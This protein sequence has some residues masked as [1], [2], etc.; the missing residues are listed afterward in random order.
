MNQEEKL[1]QEIMSEAKAQAE[2]TAAHAQA[3]ADEIIDR[4]RRDVAKKRE[5]MLAEANA[6]AE[7]QAQAMFTGI[8]MEMSRRWLLK[9][10][11]CI[12]DLLQ[13]ALAKA[14]K[15]EG[16]DR[17]A[18]LASL[19][20]EAL[21]EIGDRDCMVSFNPADGNI[22]TTAWLQGLSK[23]IYPE[24]TITYTLKPD[25][26]VDGGIVLETTDGARQ[27]DNSYKTRLLRMK[28]GLRIVIAG[29]VQDS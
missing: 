22:V 20:K 24:S 25:T 29:D 18:S 14:D 8:D 7:R 15:A 28:D 13:T 5:A 3:E 6:E 26:S 21:C 16:F 4:A 9:R 19:A 1:K 10:E 17:A 23:D 2:E 12:N 27:V 11:A